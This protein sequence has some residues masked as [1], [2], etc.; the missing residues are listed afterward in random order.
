MGIGNGTA[1]PSPT[2]GGQEYQI[3]SW[4]PH[5]VGG[6]GGGAIALILS[7]LLQEGTGR[8]YRGLSGTGKLVDLH[9]GLLLLLVV[10]GI[11]GVVVASPRLHPLVSAIPAVWLVIAFGP[12]VVGGMIPNWYPHWVSGFVLRTLGGLPVVIVG[13]LAVASVR[14]VILRQSG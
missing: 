9:I 4:A 11:V 13:I 1:R 5:A 14:S 10:G 12:A 3:G 2:H 7:W 6:L 8:F